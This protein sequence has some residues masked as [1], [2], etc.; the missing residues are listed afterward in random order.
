MAII[1]GVRGNQVTRKEQ[2]KMKKYM[3]WMRVTEEGL[4]GEWCP[5]FLTFEAESEGEALEEF[6]DDEEIFLRDLNAV[7]I[8]SREYSHIDGNA[9]FE[10]E[11]EGKMG[12]LEIK[13]IEAE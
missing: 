10:Y 7:R 5:Y 6:L 12:T 13:M 2:R 8:D 1:L 4:T 9:E 3:A 11:Y